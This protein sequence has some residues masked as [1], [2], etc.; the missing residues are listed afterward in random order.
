MKS[1]IYL[2]LEG[3][4]NTTPSNNFVLRFVLAQTKSR[5]GWSRKA[6]MKLGSPALP[7]FDNSNTQPAL[8]ARW[9]PAFEKIMKLV[10]VN[11][12]QIIEVIYNLE[13]GKHSC[14]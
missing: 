8:G 7:S 5:L 13:L 11:L 4:S 2:L 3:A 10:C 1:D 9:K 14:W 12:Q 6:E